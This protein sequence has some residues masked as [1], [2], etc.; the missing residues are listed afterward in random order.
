MFPEI[1]PLTFL[2]STL[3]DR[4]ALLREEKE[5]GYTAEAVIVIALM[6]IATITI[7]GIVVDKIT[8][9]AQGINMGN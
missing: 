5:A 7:V 3:K 6:V 8:T 1:Q 2:I 4:L 9:K